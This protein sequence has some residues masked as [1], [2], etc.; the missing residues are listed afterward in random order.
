[1]TSLSQAPINSQLPPSFT[2]PVENETTVTYLYQNA[3]RRFVDI[4]V[5]FDICTSLT[6]KSFLNLEMDLSPG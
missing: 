5:L 3:V 4:E 2:Y 6:P 1:L